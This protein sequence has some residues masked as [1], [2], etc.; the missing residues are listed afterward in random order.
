MST[1]KDKIIVHEKIRQYLIYLY[2]N[3][4]GVKSKSKLKFKCQVL[5][6][7]TLLVFYLGSYFPFHNF[8]SEAHNLRSLIQT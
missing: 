4:Y 5:T 3:K 8:N 7:Q 6:R 1:F 2:F